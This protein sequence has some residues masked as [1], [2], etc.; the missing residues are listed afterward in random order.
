[1][2]L[3]RISQISLMALFITGNVLGWHIL[4]GNLSTSRLFDILPLADPFAVLQILAV[5]KIVSSQTLLGALI[6]V[7]FFAVIGGRVFCSWV[8]PVNM[9]TDLANW[10][11]KWARL[12]ISPTNSM[13][14]KARY[15]VLGMALVISALTGVAAFEWISPISMLH[16]G[17]IFGM[18]IGWTA[19]LA[20]FLFD[21]LIVKNGFCGHLCPLGGFYSLIGRVGMVK[22]RHNK[23][24]CTLCRKCVEICPEAQVLPMVGKESG[25]VLSGDCTN[26]GRCIEVC[27]EDAMKFGLRH[28]YGKE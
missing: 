10:L 2:L 3:R 16:R 11:R 27:D 8:C 6:I 25:A 12:D 28:V 22:V 9:V 15:W 19:V 1:M 4:R 7:L 14:R 5:G 24:R 18:G 13:N 26:C 20:V 21:L 23:N 17:I